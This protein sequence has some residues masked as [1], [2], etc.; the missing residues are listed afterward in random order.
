MDAK[1][2]W[3]NNTLN[4]LN[5]IQ[6]ATADPA[7]LSNV[8]V[9][10]DHNGSNI[11]WFRQ[12]KYWQVAAGLAFLVSFNIYT[13]FYHQNTRAHLPEAPAALAADYFS[14]LGPIKL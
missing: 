2:S 6:R 7:L 13:A 3:I 10:T 14:Y 4:S 11:T 9:K 1:E 8:L 12:A 5:G